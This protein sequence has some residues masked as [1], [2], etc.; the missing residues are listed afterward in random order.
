MCHYGML[1]NLKNAHKKITHNVINLNSS[2]HDLAVGDSRSMH[3][4]EQA[5]KY[6]TVESVLNLF[7]I[8]YAK[9]QYGEDIFQC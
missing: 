2:L 8:V 4:S 3:V 6:V 1:R 9:C 5:I 7:F